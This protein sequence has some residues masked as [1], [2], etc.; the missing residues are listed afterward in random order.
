MTPQNRTPQN[1]T[2]QNG[3]PQNGRARARIVVGLDDSSGGRAALR[4]AL[5]DAARRGADVE[6][7]AA[8]DPPD[9]WP[10]VYGGPTPGDAAWTVA[11]LRQAVWSDTVRIADEVE[12]ELVDI[13]AEVPSLTITAAA[14]PA[15]DVLLR[16]A[17]DADLL[18]VG[19]RGRGGLTS[20]LLGSVSLQ[21][22]L[23]APCP[24][25][26]VRAAALPAATG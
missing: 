26:V 23:H 19:H 11:E 21:A 6:V 8:F 20:M 24:V 14:G 15:G 12:A 13:L 5:L 9:R 4:F 16:A 17:A 10:A 3:T 25:T 2:S 18:V 22:V 1:R 7:V